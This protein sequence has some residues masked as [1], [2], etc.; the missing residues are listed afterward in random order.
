[1]ETAQ[2]QTQLK[3]LGFHK[4][5]RLIY[6]A[7]FDLGRCRARDIITRAGLVRNSV[8]TVLDDFVQ[9]GL[10]SKVMVRGVAE[11]F[12]NDPEHIVHELDEQR[13]L[14]KAVAEE[15]KHKHDKHEG[16]IVILSGERALYDTFYP[17]LEELQPGEEYYVLGA[18]F[19]AE[20]ERS[21]KFFDIYHAARI[22]KGVVVNMLVSHES[23][24]PLKERFPRVGDPQYKISHMKKFISATPQPFQ[25]N[26]YKGKTRM[27]LY[28]HNPLVFCFD[29][30]G[31]YQGFKSYFDA[32]WER[33]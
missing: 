20:A 19:G 25:I 5:E 32:M 24:A 7:L 13:R 28:G 26:L 31:V 8:Y 22:K 4:N 1:M 27:I 17:M 11:F 10:V 3:K 12:V 15:L 14:A 6:L 29:R 2:I 9:R 21:T 30:P 33:T 16:E 18:T 23:Y